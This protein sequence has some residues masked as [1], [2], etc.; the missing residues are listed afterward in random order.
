MRISTTQFFESTNTNYQ[1]NYSNL[2]KTSEEVSSG[3]KLNTAGDD[4]VGA[5]RVLQLAQ[6]NSMLT[7]YETNIGTINTNVVTT[8]TTLTSI[9]DT[10]QAAREQIVSAG[11]GAFTDSDRLAK[12]SAL[13]QYQSQILGLMNSQDPNGQYIFS[14]SKASTPPYAQNADGSYSYQGDQTSVNLA[15]G[16]GLVMASNTTGFEAFEQSVNTTRTS[17]TRL[18]PAT[19][20]GKIGLSGGLVT[21]TPT[22]NASYQGGEPYT[23]TF[24]SG[25]Q[26]KITDASGTDVSS[27]T[28]SG[29]KFSHG[30]FDA[31]TFTFRGVEMT[32]NVNLPAA[33]RVSDATADAALANRSYQL[34][35][36]PD[37]VSTARSAGNTSTATVSSSAVGNT[38]ADRTA[39]NNTF[40]TEGAILKFTSPTDYDLYAAPLTSSSKPV[41]SGT[42]T[43]ST[44]NAS[45]VNFNISGTPAAG[46]QFI[47]ESG[48]HQTENILN[49]L[50][51]AIKALSTPTDGNLVA[52]QNMTAALNTA[53]GNMSSAI[54]QASTARSSGGARQL[55]ATAQ[56]TTNDLLKDNNTVEQGTYVNAD[57][58]EATTRLTLQ[59]TML[60]ASQQVFTMLSKLNLF[61]QL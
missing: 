48:T 23:L 3:I 11:S 41:S 37:S 31:Q 8:E 25:T 1:R 54:E 52:S 24:L 9:I 45:G 20:D 6:Q 21:S 30:S 33:D 59:K 38:A 46:D 39:F 60:D 44:A 2:N 32:L 27:D 29:G 55:A 19:D 26:F 43:G 40:P 61:S 51:A 49:T 18:S 16:D 15:V 13:K 4:P 10:M 50:T 35:S 53:L 42:M 12:A 5:A 7:Q 57:I 36:T 22:Y 56:G 28:S 58:V 34:A 47:V 14:G 17:A